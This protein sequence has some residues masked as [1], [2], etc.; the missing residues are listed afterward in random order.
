LE[1]IKSKDSNLFY[2]FAPYVVFSVQNKEQYAKL[3]EKFNL[4]EIIKNTPIDTDFVKLYK[5]A[6]TK[7]LTYHIPAQKAD[8]LMKKFAPNVEDVVRKVSYLSITY[9]S[10][11]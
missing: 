10:I 11:Y 5:R 2:F 3:K 6:Q 1:K 4:K 8:I 9:Q 7:K